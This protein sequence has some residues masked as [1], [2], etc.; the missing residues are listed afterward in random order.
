MP[1]IRDTFGVA[2]SREWLELVGKSGEE[3]K[4]VVEKGN[5]NVRVEIIPDGGTLP[6]DVDEDRVRIY[7][8]SA[9]KVTRVPQIG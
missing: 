4:E 5:P 3:A 1:M 8:D 2:V 6:D 7:V 9:G